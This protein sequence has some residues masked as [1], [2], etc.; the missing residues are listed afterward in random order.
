MRATAAAELLLSFGAC[1]VRPPMANAV[2]AA[3]GRPPVS[4]TDGAG[5]APRGGARDGAPRGCGGPREGGGAHDGAPRSPLALRDP[6]EGAG[7]TWAC[8]AA[9]GGLTSALH[10]GQ[11]GLASSHERMHLGSMGD[12]WGISGGSRAD[13]R[14]I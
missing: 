13:H 14:E 10:S 1:R 4:C 8:R 12:Q 11:V 3:T 6:R 5:G 9:P 2:C 7:T